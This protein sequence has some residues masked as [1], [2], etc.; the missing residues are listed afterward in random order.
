MAP[1]G[2]QGS[3]VAVHWWRGPMQ[4]SDGQLD[5]QGES[6]EL[7]MSFKDTIRFNRSHETAIAVRYNRKPRREKET[8]DSEQE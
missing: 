8:T 3:K 1:G 6:E 7:K 2:V 5:T 4:S